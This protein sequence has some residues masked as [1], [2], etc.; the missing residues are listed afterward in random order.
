MLSVK[1]LA[2]VLA[3]LFVRPWW[4]S[5]LVAAAV[6]GTEPL[7]TF[8]LYGSSLGLRTPQSAMY[9]AAALVGLLLWLAC[10]GL[11]WWINRRNRPPPELA[12]AGRSNDAG[13][14]DR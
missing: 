10:W 2:P 1:L 6:A 12:S 13:A 5:A 7:L 3:A 8:W 4:A 9:R 14:F 11:G